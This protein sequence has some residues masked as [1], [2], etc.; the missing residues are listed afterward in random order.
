[1]KSFK[2]LLLSVILSFTAC[3]EEVK[4][5]E[6]K[7][8]IQTY[9]FHKF[10]LMETLDKSKDLGLHYAEAYFFQTLG[11]NFADTAYLNFDITDNVKKQLKEEFA[12]R[13]IKLYAFGVAFYDATEDWE[14]FFS[15]SKDMGIHTITCEPKLEHLDFVEELALKYN[16]EV[17]IH[18][19]PDPSI[20]ADPNV[21]FGALEGR[22]QIMGVCA[23]IGHWKRT[24]NDPIETLK[25]FE[26]RIKVVH[27]KDLDEKMKDT[28]W[29]TGVLQVKEVLNELKRQRFN[30]LI[31]VEY[32][33][34]GDSQLDDIKKSLE[35]FNQNLN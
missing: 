6:W 4:Q 32:E 14:R 5:P 15:F 12:K 26:G 22:N 21:L 28:T 11:G 29:G 34:F 19:H 25:K 9:T 24:G 1:M 20:Y 30:G 13:D 3:K 2:L 8:G 27:I 23:D 33:D 7:L 17:A 35:Y 10:T 31:S 18:N 16:I